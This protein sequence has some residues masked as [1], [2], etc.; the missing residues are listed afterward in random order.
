MGRPDPGGYQNLCVR[1]RAELTQ[2]Y[3]V[4]VQ[5]RVG[6]HGVRRR[7]RFCGNVEGRRAN[8]RAGDEHQLCEPDCELEG[9]GS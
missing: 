1:V 5:S 6:A 7:G 3:A 2:N 4:L 9:V 8:A